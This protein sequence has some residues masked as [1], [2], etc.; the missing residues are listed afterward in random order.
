[1]FK[2]NNNIISK[3]N[4]F[5]ISHSIL[6][7]ALISIFPLISFFILVSKLGLEN[8]GIII[9]NF[10]F[11]SFFFI[12]INFGFEY[13]LLARLSRIKSKMIIS[14][15]FF[16][17]L[18]IKIFI[19]F[20]LFIVTYLFGNFIEIFKSYKNIF[21]L[22][23]FQISLSALLPILFYQSNEYFL[24]INLLELLS[25][26][27][28]LFLI[29]N[30]LNHQ[31]EYYKVPLYH[32]ISLTLVNIISYVFLYKKLKINYF[33]F[34][35]KLILKLL[36]KSKIFVFTRNLNK[37]FMDFS[38]FLI[39]LYWG[40]ASLGTFSSALK[41]IHGISAI[42]NSI[43][44]VLFPIVSKN[45]LNNKKQI[46][47][48]LIIFCGFSILIILGCMLI[49]IYKINYILDLIFPKIENLQNLEK[50]IMF[51][52]F[53]PILIFINL[54]FVFGYLLP[55]KKDFIYNKI[56]TLTY[57]FYIFVSLITIPVFGPNIFKFIL[58]FAELSTILLFCFYIF[59]YEKK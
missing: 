17:I 22:T 54:C 42:F 21:L 15:Y 28:F 9:F 38:F 45:I 55:L 33:K 56:L 49:F 58:I 19:I 30:F 5:H 25:K 51:W 36:S 32:I 46:L 59:G 14:A 27:I 12:L 48:D 50:L 2:L 11:F 34:K 52:S 3:K 31:N 23:Y 1:M 47:R 7:R 16:N 8:Y 53:L 43:F 41:L 37:I 13:S 26:I 10:S 18:Y 44:F 29:F 35:L 24:E 20:I 4:L 57:V 39:G 6:I 40:N